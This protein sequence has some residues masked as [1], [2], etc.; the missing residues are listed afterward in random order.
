M[1]SEMCI[2]DRGEPP[3]KVFISYA[4]ADFHYKE[5]LMKYLAGLKRE[6]LIEVWEDGRLNPGDQWDD[7]IR[8]QLEQADWAIMLLSQAFIQSSYIYE[9]ELSLAISKLNNSGAFRLLPIII[10]ECDWASLP[11]FLKNL[12]SELESDTGSLD[13]I[14]AMPRG[15]DN[16]DK[17]I[18]K[19]INEWDLPNK[20]WMEVVKQLRGLIP[21]S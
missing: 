19:P 12:Q 1:G 21:R 20:A 3:K 10:E 4:H 17:K 7:E 9:T 11:R 16:N 6:K 18:L 15:V 8:R 2:R 14:Q 13:Q 5:E